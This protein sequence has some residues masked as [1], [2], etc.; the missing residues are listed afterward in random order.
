[1]KHEANLSLKITAGTVQKLQA[2]LRHTLS[3]EQRIWN[4]F[5]KY[6][7]NTILGALGSCM[8]WS[9]TCVK[10]DV[11]CDHCDMTTFKLS[12]GEGS[13]A[14]ADWSSSVQRA[15]RVQS[16]LHLAGTGQLQQLVR[17][18]R[19]PCKFHSCMLK[20][21]CYKRLLAAYSDG[22]AMQRQQSQWDF[23]SNGLSKCG[24]RSCKT[25]T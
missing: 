14:R 7:A 19:K 10:R 15:G 12:G 24:P 20:G 11:T 2:C 6:G 22:C 17:K 18:T 5:V 13:A 8:I 25:S 9:G 23:G 1:M 21:L 4:H 3:C 16:L